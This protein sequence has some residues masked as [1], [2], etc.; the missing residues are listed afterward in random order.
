M[1]IIKK[2]TVRKL[3]NGRKMISGFVVDCES[4]PCDLSEFIKMVT[5]ETISSDKVGVLCLK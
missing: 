3:K 2:G 1:K 5:G 4:G